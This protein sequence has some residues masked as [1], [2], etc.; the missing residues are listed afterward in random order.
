MNLNLD[1]GSWKRV[2]LGDVIRRSRKQVDPVSSGIER[3][4]AGGHVDSEGITIKRWG[5]LGDGQMGSTF[6]YVFGPGQL[7]FVSARPYLRKVGVPDFGGIVADKTYVLD[8]VL[9]N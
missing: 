4:V 7:L 9:E 8:A 1:K 3:Y 6:R 5:H 2:R